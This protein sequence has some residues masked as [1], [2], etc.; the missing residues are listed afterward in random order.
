[1]SNLL[2]MALHPGWRH[3]AD[4]HPSSN[5]SWQ[6]RLAKYS[7]IWQHSWSQDV[8]KPN[9]ECPWRIRARPCSKT[10]AQS[11]VQGKARHIKALNSFFVIVFGIY[12]KPSQLLNASLSLLRHRQGNLYLQSQ[13]V[14]SS[15]S[16]SPVTPHTHRHNRG[17]KSCSLSRSGQNLGWEAG[18]SRRT[19]RWVC[20]WHQQLQLDAPRCISTNKP[21]SPASRKASC[22]PQPLQKGTNASF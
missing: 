1:M 16:H 7:E 5:R 21:W 14:Q 18:T 2:A 13:Q 3:H 6:P 15:P 17:E 11:L 20:T 8:K 10:D 4:V 9:P 22:V 12:Y 19:E